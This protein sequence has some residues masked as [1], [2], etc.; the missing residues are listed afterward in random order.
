MRE[1]L[2]KAK[3]IDNGEEVEGS[4][5]KSLTEKQAFAPDDSGD[6]YKE[7]A[8]SILPTGGD[9]SDGDEKEIDPKTI[10]QYTGL[11]DKNGVKIFEGDIC[12]YKQYIGDIFLGVVN[13]CDA[14][15][16]YYIEAIG[17][18]DE[19]NQDLEIHISNKD[20]IERIGNKFDNPEL[21]EVT[22]WTNKWNKIDSEWSR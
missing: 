21:C 3:R 20:D 18:D 1:I 7:L 5:I 9:L 2:F 16:S 12:K 15:F 19:G 11:D 22:K 10:C 13:F 6:Y 17:G 14:S 8:H 4:Y